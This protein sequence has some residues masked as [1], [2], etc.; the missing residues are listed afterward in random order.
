MAA[1]ASGRRQVGGAVHERYVGDRLGKI[2]Q[3]ALCVRVVFFRQESD[4][5]AKRQEPLKEPARIAMA[6]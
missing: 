5:I 6:A 1:R 2:A 4:V 3:Q